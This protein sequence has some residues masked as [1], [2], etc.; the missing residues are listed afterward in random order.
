M[1]S[2]AL[3]MGLQELLR[4]LARLKREFGDNEEYRAWRLE[5]PKD[6]PL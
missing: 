6:W 1:V 4:T 3:K 5:F 2:S